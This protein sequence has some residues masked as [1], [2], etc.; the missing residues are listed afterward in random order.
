MT[1]QLIRNG[2][3]ETNSSSTHSVSVTVDPDT[4]LD[5][6]APDDDG[7]IRLHGMQFGWEV[8]NYDD[9][10]TKMVYALQYLTYINNPEYIQ[11]FYDVVKEHTGASDIIIDNFDLRKFEYGYGY[12]DHQSVD[13]SDINSVFFDRDKLKMFIFSSK[14][15]L[16]TDNDNY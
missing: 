1:K 11:Q 5:G 8:E 10:Y 14:S 12:I 6:Y 15:V 7:I 9:V 13:D 3:F 4:V 2:V 16:H